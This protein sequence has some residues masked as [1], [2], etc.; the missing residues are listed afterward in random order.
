MKKGEEKQC[1]VC[2]HRNL[3]EEKASK[4]LTGS[5]LLINLILKETVQEGIFQ[6]HFNME[7]V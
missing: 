3:L 7:M 6:E 4:K 1:K 2:L 5:I